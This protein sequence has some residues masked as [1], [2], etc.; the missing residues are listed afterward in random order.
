MASLGTQR[1]GEQVAGELERASKGRV[2]R[3]KDGP[4]LGTVSAA[5]VICVDLE[6]NE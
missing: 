2:W 1:A 5:S 6:L 3:G 4:F